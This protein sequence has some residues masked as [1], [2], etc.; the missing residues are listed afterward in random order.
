[1]DRPGIGR[2]DGVT[3]GGHSMEKA[4][5]PFNLNRFLIAQD[6]VY[7]RVIKELRLGHK[8]SHWMWFIFPQVRGLGFSAMAQQY[9]IS[10]LQEAKAYLDHAILGQRL[11]ECTQLVLDTEGLTIRQ[12][13]GSPDY[14]KF[15]SCMT[16]FLNAAADNELF[17]AALSKYCGGEPDHSTVEQLSRFKDTP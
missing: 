17:A 8:T 10:S 16:L 1:M 11:R 5:D 2:K 9:A 6:R 12:I 7:P 15:R 13:L 14:L 3:T 4:T